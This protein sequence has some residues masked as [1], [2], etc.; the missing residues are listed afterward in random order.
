MVANSEFDFETRTRTSYLVVLEWIGDGFTPLDTVQPPE[1]PE[2]ETVTFTNASGRSTSVSDVPFVHNPRWR[3]ARD[4]SLWV[5]E[6]GGRYDIRL[7]GRDGELLRRIGRDYAPVEIEASH[8]REEIEG[9]VQPGWKRVTAFDASSVPHVYP[10]FT[11]VRLAEDGSVWVRRQVA[12][13]RYVRE[14]FDADDRFLGRLDVPE[15]LDGL[16]IHHVGR[17]HVWGVVRD[18]LDVQYVVRARI[19]RSGE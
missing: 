14:I 13:D 16:R 3:L 8:R 7:L 18:E 4:G 1:L 15:T 6:G 19:E 12:E 17:D 9:L 10:P 5:W 11:S 2:P